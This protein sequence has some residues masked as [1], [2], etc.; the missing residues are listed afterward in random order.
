M[1]GMLSKIYYFL[2]TP[3]NTRPKNKSVLGWISLYFAHFSVNSVY[4]VYFPLFNSKTSE[5]L[6]YGK[7]QLR[8]LHKTRWWPADDRLH[9]TPDHLTRKIGLTTSNATKK[10]I[11]KQRSTHKM[12]PSSV[13]R[14]RELTRVLVQLTLRDE[15]SN[16]GMRRNFG[17]I[18]LGF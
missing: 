11:T 7:G 8:P 18:L 12:V 9:M 14:N 17:S 13:F 15:H 4:S 16:S 1:G 5:N 6:D 3:Q 10:T 2:F